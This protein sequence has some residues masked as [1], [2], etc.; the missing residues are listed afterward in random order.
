MADDVPSILNAIPLGLVVAPIEAPEPK[1]NAPLD[2]L[3]IATP[4]VV[5]SRVV[6]P[7]KLYVPSALSNWRPLP[8][9]AER[10]PVLNVIVP[11]CPP[12]TETSA[13]VIPGALETFPG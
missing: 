4:L 6:V 12:E 5:P 3:T 11:V 1:V 10:V 8:L 7:L 9:N 13:P 2:P